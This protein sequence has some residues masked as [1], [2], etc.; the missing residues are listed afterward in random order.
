MINSILFRYSL[1][2]KQLHFILMNQMFEKYFDVI[3]KKRRF[4]DYFINA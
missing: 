3:N 1:P 4:F 2:I